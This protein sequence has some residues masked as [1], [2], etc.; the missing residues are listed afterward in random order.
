MTTRIGERRAPLERIDQVD[1]IAA[2]RP[3]AAR[4]RG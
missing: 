1:R 3:G 2:G 4:P